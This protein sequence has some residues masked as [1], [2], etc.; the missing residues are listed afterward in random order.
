MRLL[1]LLF[2]FLYDALASILSFWRPVVLFTV[3]FVCIGF[4]QASYVKKTVCASGCD[5]TAATFAPTATTGAI[6]DAQTY[7]DG[8]ACVPYIIEIQAG[9]AVIGGNFG[10]ASSIQIPAK[11]CREKVILRSSRE[12]EIG[13]RRLNTST[14]T[15]LLA[16]IKTPQ[17]GSGALLEIGVNVLTG[18]WEFRGLELTTIAPNGEIPY[19]ATLGNNVSP[20][21]I[22]PDHIVLDH[23]W[24]HGA[25]LEPGPQQCLS[26]AG[27]NHSLTN[28]VFGNCNTVSV[29]STSY[30]NGDSKDVLMNSC[31]SCVVMNNEFEGSTEHVY[32]TFGSRMKD[33][34]NYYHNSPLLKWSTSN[35]TNTP[36]SNPC[37][38]DA[39]GGEFYLNAAEQGAFPGPAWVGAHVIAVSNNGGVYQVVVTG[40]DYADQTLA[41]INSAAGHPAITGLWTLDRT[42]PSTYNLHGSTYYGDAHSPGGGYITQAYGAYVCSGGTWSSTTTGRMQPSL[43]NLRESKGHYF[44]DFYGNVLKSNWNDQQN[45]SFLQ[46]NEF[47]YSPLQYTHFYGNYIQDVPQGFQQGQT[48]YA[49]NGWIDMHDNL[50][51]CGYLGQIRQPPTAAHGNAIASLICCG[52]AANGIVNTVNSGLNTDVTQVSGAN[53]YSGMVGKSIAING[54]PTQVLTFT[55]G[56]PNHILVSG[57]FGTLSG[58]AW[59]VNSPQINDPI[60]AHNTAVCENLNGNPNM[61]SGFVGSFPGVFA[62]RGVYKENIVTGAQNVYTTYASPPLSFYNAWTNMWSNIS[63]LDNAN[64]TIFQITSQGDTSCGTLG[65]PLGGS[66]NWACYSA[67]SSVFVNYQSDGSGD[68]HVANGVTNKSATDRPG[69]TG[70]N[71]D[72]MKVATAHAIDGAHNSFLDAEFKSITPASTTAVIRY[73]APDSGACTVEVSTSPLFGSTVYSAADGGGNPS[74]AVTTTAV[75]SPHTPYY[76]QVRNCGSYGANVWLPMLGMTQVPFVTTP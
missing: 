12:G 57:N 53:L 38:S 44:L 33:Y 55:A 67:Y 63:S 47:A 17:A 8:T 11:T 25:V 69:D 24:I 26:L 39:S 19:L 36:P 58:V 43:K 3:L 18:G 9:Y 35:G 1:I 61:Y 66:A 42:A 52:D 48:D 34:G 22:L 72:W 13:N 59:S 68:Y 5:Y 56:S 20:P 6:A 32:N 46:N 28:S 41:F 15:A 50:N 54:N 49:P 7:Q 40:I 37:Y 31:N 75:L 27:T 65:P 21:Y 10:T 23:M 29:A 73:V 4:T 16:T 70:A 60:L 14:D 71:I 62:G 30:T 74:R 51:L 64:N 76:A 2:A 45:G